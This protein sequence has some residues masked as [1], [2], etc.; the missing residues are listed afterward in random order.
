MRSL[1]LIGILL[2]LI[3]G[4]L[5]R[6]RVRGITDLT[7][8]PRDVCRGYLT[9]REYLE[10]MI[11]HHQVAIDISIQHQKE[12]RSPVLQQLM[13]K[14]V[15]TQK[16][17]IAMMHELKITAGDEYGMS[18]SVGMQLGYGP[19]TAGDLAKPNEIGLTQ[20]Y[21]DPH[22]FDPDAHADHM[23]KMDI[24]DVMYIKHMIP[25][26]QVAVDMSKVL[27]AN[28]NNDY[29]IYMAHRI[30]RSQQEEIALLHNLLAEHNFN[31]QSELLT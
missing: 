8:S 3:A 31:M 4:F 11:P 9:D 30:I 17:E 5:W 14:L 23:E 12:S 7:N 21:C 6:L 24:T 27:L 25:H 19:I 2:A 22:F 20:T 1:L 26:H 29:M 15:W 10:H 16:R 28:T 18:S 13:R